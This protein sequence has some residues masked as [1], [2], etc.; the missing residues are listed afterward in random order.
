MKKMMKLFALLL[1]VGLTTAV[2]AQTPKLG[3]INLQELVQ[4]MPER[5][6]AETE[7]NS[8]QTEL[9]DVLG[10]MQQGYQQKIQELENLGEN[11]SEVK[12]NAKISELQDIQQRI[13]SY[14]ST[15]QQQL[16]QKQAELLQPVFEKAE[17]AIQEVAKEEGLMYVFDTGS[18]VV[19]YKS[20]ESVDILPLVKKKLGLE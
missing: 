4:L 12:R 18:N 16:Q 3:H 19:L 20:N 10:E 8:F 6:S 9:E 11:V 1:F 15:A 14:Q 13:Q 17:N 2:G 7:F 5:A